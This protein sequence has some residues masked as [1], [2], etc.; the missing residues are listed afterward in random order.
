MTIFLFLSTTLTCTFAALCSIYLLIR[1]TATFQKIGDVVF[2]TSTGF[3]EEL[4]TSVDH[5][6]ITAK[7]LS[8]LSKTQLNG[9]N[10]TKNPFQQVGQ[11]VYTNNVNLVV[12]PAQSSSTEDLEC[13]VP[14][15]ICTAG[16]AHPSC[17]LSNFECRDDHVQ[18]V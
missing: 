13:D 5:S 15:C 9:Q 11:S 3:P 4:T 1:K 8:A 6:L 7:L 10:L 12:P 18:R 2:E 16:I 14:V 17:T